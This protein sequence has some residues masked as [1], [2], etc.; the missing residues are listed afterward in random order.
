MLSMLTPYPTDQVA[1][2]RVMSEKVVKALAR[3]NMVTAWT[4]ASCLYGT[5]AQVRAARKL[6]RKALRPYATRIAFV[7]PGE[8]RL[9]KRLLSWVPFAKWT[10]YWNIVERL[11]A[12]VTN[13][14]GRPSDIALPLAYWRGGE[15]QAG[16]EMDPSGDGCGLIWYSPLVPMKAQRVRAYVE[17]VKRTC[18]EYG[19]EPLITLTS[20][21]ERCFDSTVPLLFE[22]RDFEQTARAK[23]CYEALF[24][25]GRQEGFLPYRVSIDLMDKVV[26]KEAPFWNLA[27]KIKRTLDPDNILAPGRYAALP[28]TEEKEAL[29]F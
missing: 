21:S 9:A 11:E 24:E 16:R 15:R 20:V 28:A 10:K 14:A 4:G 25:R 2:G 7:T 3:Q 13:F 1:P 12:A 29:S 18:V 27:D 17:L 5:V 8:I 19:L 22:R 26:D 23:A 6:I